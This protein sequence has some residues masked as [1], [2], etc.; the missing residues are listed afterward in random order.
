MS[1]ALTSWKDI[2]AYLGKGVRTVQRWEQHLGLPV[3][4]PAAQRRV[5]FAIPAELDAWIKKQAKPSPGNRIVLLEELRESLA[6]LRANRRILN[7][8]ITRLRT[9][10]RE[11]AGKQSKS[12]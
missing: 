9:R 2:A 8:E 6:R 7:S 11:V 5:V 1:A 10:I 3:R 4:R 12:D